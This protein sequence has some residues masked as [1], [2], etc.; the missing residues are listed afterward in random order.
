MLIGQQQ[1][2]YRSIS[3]KVNLR[4]SWLPFCIKTNTSQ[5]NSRQLYDRWLTYIST[6]CFYI[7]VYFS[8]TLCRIQCSINITVKYVYDKQ[9]IN[10]YVILSFNW[11]LQRPNWNPFCYVS[12]N[13]LSKWNP[14]IRKTWIPEIFSGNGSVRINAGPLYIEIER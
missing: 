1:D 9:L 8:N 6:K 10:V 14:A 13:H 3:V 11:C 12:Q 4:V 7:P 2:N 5:E